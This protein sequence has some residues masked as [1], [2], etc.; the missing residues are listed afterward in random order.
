MDQQLVRH[1]AT[2]TGLPMEVAERVIADVIAYFGE[3]AEEFVRRRHAELQRRGRK[4]AEIWRLIAAEL[5]GRPLGAVPLSERQLR[6]I[7]YG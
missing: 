6:R 7:V 2:S 1:V 3:T 4:N 5:K